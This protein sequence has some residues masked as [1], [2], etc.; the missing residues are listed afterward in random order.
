MSSDNGKH[1]GSRIRKLEDLFRP[2][3][4]PRCQGQEWHVRIGDEPMPD[5]TCPD[6][7]RKIR[8]LHIAA[9]DDDDARE[10]S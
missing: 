10:V 9:D 6:C 1:P 4:C 3:A 5:S 8:V 2:P 7:G